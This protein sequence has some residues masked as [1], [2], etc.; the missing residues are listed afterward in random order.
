[1]DTSCVV[2]LFNSL[3]HATQLASA[4]S[5]SLAEP[6]GTSRP[7]DVSRPSAQKN[8]FKPPTSALL[9]HSVDA[10]PV[11]LLKPEARHT[12]REPGLCRLKETHAKRAR[13]ASAH[14]R[15]HLGPPPRS[16][17][18]LML[19]LRIHWDKLQKQRTD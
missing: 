14:A 10:T 16:L 5:P 8:Q 13:A 12:P 7:R 9:H 19:K 3:G 18:V 4:L 17:S 1:M 15:P 11:H 6:M 2:S